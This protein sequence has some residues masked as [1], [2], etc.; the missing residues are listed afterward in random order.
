MAMLNNQ[1]VDT[2]QLESSWDY[3]WSAI[4][5]DSFMW[6]VDTVDCTST[7]CRLKNSFNWLARLDFWPNDF[8]F[9][10]LC[11]YI[12]LWREIL[13]N[14]FI[15]LEIFLVTINYSAMDRSFT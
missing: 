2:M 13:A 3:L 9:S 15:V 7:S 5:K 1:M 11:I 10:S 12:V 14:L 8:G 4:Q 6:Q